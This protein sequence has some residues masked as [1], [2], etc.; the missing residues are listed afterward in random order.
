[1]PTGFPLCSNWWDEC[2]SIWWLLGTNK[3]KARPDKHAIFI[4]DGAPALNNP[5]IPGPNTEL[6]TILPYSPFLNI[7]EQAISSLKA[8]IKADISRSEI[9]EQMNNREEARCQ[10][11]A[12]GN[13]RTQLLQQALQ[14]NVGTITAAK[15]GQWFRF[16]QTYLMHD[17]SILRQ[18]RDKSFSDFDILSFKNKCYCGC[19]VCPAAIKIVIFLDMVV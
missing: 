11:F 10:G 16:M 15:C 12:L 18:L 6:K 9:Q 14:R 4:Y 1:M 7:V 3:I 5:A 17:A 8:A 13:Y 2:A 19:N